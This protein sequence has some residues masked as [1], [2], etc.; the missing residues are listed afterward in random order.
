MWTW[1]KRPREYIQEDFLGPEFH[2]RG[3]ERSW[4]VFWW[5]VAA[6]EAVGLT[7]LG[8]SKVGVKIGI[9]TAARVSILH[10]TDNRD[11]LEILDLFPV[12]FVREFTFLCSW[13]DM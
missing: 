12:V 11:P 6:L 1:G 5:D 10:K 7:C 4:F 8:G 3:G 9:A 13:P 2:H